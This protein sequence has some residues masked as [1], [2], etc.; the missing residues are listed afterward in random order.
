MNHPSALETR[1][2]SQGSI[3]EELIAAAIAGLVSNAYAQGEN[4][5]VA[6]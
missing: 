2:G 4:A 1:S 5:P 3:T 6:E